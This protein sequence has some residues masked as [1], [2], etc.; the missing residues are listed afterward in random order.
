MGII[1]S[2]ERGFAA[3]LMILSMNGEAAAPKAVG[4]HGEMNERVGRHISPEDLAAF[5]QQQDEL[6]APYK[7]GTKVG[8]PLSLS[9]SAYVRG[10]RVDVPTAVDKAKQK[11]CE[12]VG[13]VE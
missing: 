6:N 1:G 4:Q 13:P 11:L 12:E 10:Q 9:G 7:P 8:C 2:I 5:Q 3:G